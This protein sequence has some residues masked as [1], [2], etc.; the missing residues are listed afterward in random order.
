[1]FQ[2]VFLRSTPPSTG[3]SKLPSRE[4]FPEPLLN[5]QR[6]VGEASSGSRKAE[7]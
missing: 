3:E 7:D 1:M 6:A 2:P 5:G 4:S